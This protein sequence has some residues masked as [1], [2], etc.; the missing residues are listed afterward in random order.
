M[1][2]IQ[3]GKNNPILAQMDLNSLKWLKWYEKNLNDFNELKWMLVRV[4]HDIFY[5]FKV[6]YRMSKIMK[7]CCYELF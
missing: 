2:E 3:W 1:I 5:V 6:A 7:G 4:R